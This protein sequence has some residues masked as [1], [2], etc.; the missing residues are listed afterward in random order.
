[1]TS[2]VLAGLLLR[3]P[4]QPFRFVLGD[5]TE[6]SVRWRGPGQAQAR[7]PDR[8][9]VLQQRRRVDHRPRPRGVIEVEGGAK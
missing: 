1:M 3:Q 5:N 7:R 6:V 4:F 8:G 9:R 2:Q